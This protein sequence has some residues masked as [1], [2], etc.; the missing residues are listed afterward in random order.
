MTPVLLIHIGAGVLGIVS[1]AVAIAA[2]KGARLH[3]AAGTVF[4]GAMLITAAL[5]IYLAGFVPPSAAGAAPPQASIAVGLLTAYLVVT[6]WMT[7][8]RRQ[9]RDAAFEKLAFPAALGIAATLLFFGL[10]AAN[11]PPGSTLVAPYFVFAGFAAFL[12]ALDLKVIVQGGIS[13]KA[14]IARHL[15]R[16]CFALFFATAFFFLGQQKVMPVGLR[17]SPVLLALGFAPL[18]FLVF[19]LIRVRFG[20]AFASA[21]QDS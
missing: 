21:P 20:K 1:G 10:R 9:A 4:F 15:W 6:A 8:R 19:W 14:R 13:G 18:A 16:M 17:G 3:R 11:A 7:A 2:R 12:A 5:A